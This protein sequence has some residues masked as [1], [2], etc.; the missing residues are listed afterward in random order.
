MRTLLIDNYDS[1]THNLYQLMAE[2]TQEPPIVVSNDRITMQEI[3]DLEVGA[4]VISPGPGRPEVPRDFGIC[5]EVL[6]HSPVPILGVC[7][8]HQGICQQAGA[9][10]G[11]ADEVMHGRLSLVHHEGCDLLR[12]LPSPFSVVRYHSLMVRD[13]PDS[14][15]PLAWT[16]D[17][18]LMA[19]R[20]RTRPQWGVQ[21][22]P[23]SI[24]TQHGPRLMTNF[25]QLARA[26]QSARTG[27]AP[28]GFRHLSRHRTG[29]PLVETA[30]RPEAGSPAAPPPTTARTASNPAVSDTTPQFRL[31]VRK[32]QTTVSA[33]RLFAHRFKDAAH[34]FWLD[35][36]L[37]TDRT[38]FS[39]MG[40]ASGPHAEIVRFDVAQQCVCVLGRGG[41]SEHRE[42]LFAYLRRTLRERF[43]PAG[44]LPFDFNLGYVGY[45]GYELKAE[46]GGVL[47]HPSPLPD[48]QLIFADRLV[49]FDHEE[50]A[51]YLICL[52]DEGTTE[53]THAWFEALQTC[54]E[55]LEAPELPSNRNAL[56]SRMMPSFDRSGSLPRHVIPRHSN[57]RYLE[58]IAACLREIREGESYELCLTN[59][60]TI[61]RRLEPW[62]T[63]QA[64]RH[65]NP[66]PYAAFLNFPG[67]AILC[68][69]PERFL[70]VNRHGT[71]EARPI[72][73]TRPRGKTKRE[74][75]EM[76]L[77]LEHSEKDR[78]ENLMI[79]DL[80]RN[81]LGSVCQVG[82]IHVP[83]LFEV[84]SYATVHQLVSTV[85]G[86][87]RED[88]ST[89]ECV[90]AAF[91]G[92]SM[93]G[94]PKK[95]TM[96]ILDRLEQGPRGVY[97]GAIGY[98]ALNGATDLNIVIR[99]IVIAEDEISCGAGGA[100]VA[101]SDPKEE[102]AEMFLKVDAL[103]DAI[104][105]T[106]SARDGK[107]AGSQAPP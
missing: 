64:L 22:H 57:K 7:L 34:G 58:L 39:Y 68:S 27:R 54:F 92:G 49:V 42:G 50:G 90:R 36:A 95:R 69:S 100:I 55:A 84:E 37:E 32:L 93:T 30:P 105:V 13:I 6:Q 60:L 63:Y 24:L 38:R 56:T 59:H 89:I 98:F 23:E 80:L 40:D 35:S 67:L 71:V 8:G 78:A 11:H 82:S 62:R 14:L 75:Q 77:E 101:L 5:E 2:L 66:A 26:H 88:V 48:A 45:L 72:K 65:V 17:Q 91:P 3:S 51:Q 28:K 74:D 85:Q 52:E 16:A 104:A 25:F 4:I 47:V 61:A 12:G 43:L 96:E 76:A 103:L 81:D 19:I 94:A 10:V 79:V 31:R 46:C 18:V 86:Q 21:F 106:G 53:D 107:T 97:S 41:I 1:F 73:G 29:E 99:T 9:T 102:L 15:E 83:Q 87:L 33:E 44:D 70:T 20:H